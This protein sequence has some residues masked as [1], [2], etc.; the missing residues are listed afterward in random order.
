MGDKDL[1]VRVVGIMWCE[2]PMMGSKIAIQNH[3]KYH[4]ESVF[5][6]IFCDTAAC[7]K[8]RLI[9]PQQKISRMQIG[10]DVGSEYGFGAANI[11]IALNE[12]EGHVRIKSHLK[13]LAVNQP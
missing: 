5:K 1:D 10:F 6:V 13:V 7:I 8:T 4:A 9:C 3:R 12:L 2:H 11:V